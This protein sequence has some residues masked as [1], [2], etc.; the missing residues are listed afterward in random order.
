MTLPVYLP[1][2]LLALGRGMLIPVLPIYAAS[3]DVSYSWIGIALASQGVGTMVGDIPAGMLLGSISARRVMQLGILCSGIG[4]LAI[5]L[6]HSFWA[7]VAFSFVTG[8]GQ[9]LYNISRMV[10]LR[11]E[12]MVHER[13]RAIALFGGVNRIGTFAG[14]VVGGYFAQTFGLSAPF[15]VFAIL[16]FMATV[17]PTFYAIEQRPQR[18][19]LPVGQKHNPLRALGVL[20]RQNSSVLIPASIGQFFAQGIRSGR[21]I[22]V[23]LYAADVLGLDLSAIG[24][25]VT[26]AAA[27]DMSL[28]YPAGLI[29]DR[30][31]RKFAYVPS[32]LIQGI[33][34]ALVPLTGG[35]VG[36]TLAAS[37]M[38]FGNG[39]SS[40]SMMT[41]GT[42][43]APPGS[44]GEFLGVW[45]LIGDMG[46][47]GSPLVVG[48]VADLL[49]LP[50]ATLVIAIMGILAGLTLGLFVPET[51]QKS[52]RVPT[53]VP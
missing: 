1:T 35:F 32:F 19:E 31:G 48:S 43:L 17:F 50:Y 36:L 2:W 4:M 40:G 45:R 28:F 42:D 29:M 34:M 51:L 7:L 24:W 38:G 18:S 25:I 26:I 11:N 30:L 49:S 8:V 3:F 22:I 16:A 14:P 12:T 41:L 47:T 44:A 53:P 23:P 33:A 52:A 39:L 27:I 15:L 6:S 5:A 46:Q 9:A 10:Y 37:L 13:G 21:Q 20:L